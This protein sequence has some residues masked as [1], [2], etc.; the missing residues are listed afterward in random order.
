MSEVGLGGQVD[1][2]AVRVRSTILNISI[3]SLLENVFIVN[4]CRSKIERSNE[5]KIKFRVNREQFPGK[6]NKIGSLHWYGR[7]AQP[8]I[9]P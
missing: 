2:I 5:I 1:Y 3:N 6:R 8:G 4:Y 9:V 7:P